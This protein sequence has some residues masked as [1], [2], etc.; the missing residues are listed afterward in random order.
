LPVEQQQQQPELVENNKEV[1][2]HNGELIKV[3]IHIPTDKVL[4]LLSAVINT[5]RLMPIPGKKIQPSF[6]SNK[7]NRTNNS[8]GNKRITAILTKFT[9]DLLQFLVSHLLLLLLLSYKYA[10]MFAVDVI[11]Y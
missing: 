9:F 3:A 6:L 8:I 2:F 1:G 5:A 10:V 4:T 7:T 11:C